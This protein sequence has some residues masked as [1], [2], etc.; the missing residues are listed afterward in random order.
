MP[1]RCFVVCDFEL[2]FNTLPSLDRIFVRSLNSGSY[3][4]RALEYTLVCLYLHSL[5]SLSNPSLQH[6]F[7]T[8]SCIFFSFLHQPQTFLSFI[9]LFSCS[10]YF[11]LSSFFLI[12]SHVLQ[13]ELYPL[14]LLLFS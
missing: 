3:C 8:Y 2:P 11:C 6:L 4:F 14:F 10:E 7:F 9:S 1:I 5:H 12:F 13:L